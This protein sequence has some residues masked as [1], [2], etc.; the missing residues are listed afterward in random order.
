MFR[1]IFDYEP[2]FEKL[3]YL[4]GMDRYLNFA[5]FRC[6]PQLR[7]CKYFG[8]INI[9]LTCTKHEIMLSA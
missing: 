3:A 7:N 6:Q 2:E 1:I 4:N 9:K 5:P 8:I